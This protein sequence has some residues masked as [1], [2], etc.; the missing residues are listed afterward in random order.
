MSPQDPAPNPDRDP[1]TAP[2]EEEEAAPARR[3]MEGTDLLVKI[4]F[5]VIFVLL[6]TSAWAFIC[7]G[8]QKGWMV[9]LKFIAWAIIFGAF[10]AN[11]WK[12][13]VRPIG[14][15]VAL[16]LLLSFAWLAWAGSYHRTRDLLCMGFS[17]GAVM[18]L[19]PRGR[20]WLKSLYAVIKECAGESV[21]TGRPVIPN[22]TKHRPLKGAWGF[23]FFV[24]FVFLFWLTSSG[25]NAWNVGAPVPTDPARFAALY[26]KSPWRDVRVGVA[27]SGGGYRAVLMHAGVLDAF[28][29]LGVPVT[30]MTSVSGGSITGAFYAAGGE[31]RRLRAAINERRFNLT[32]NMTDAQN[33][34]RLPFPFKLPWTDVK[35][36][37]WYSFTRSDVQSALLDSVLLDQK[38]LSDLKRGAGAPRLM[39]CTTDLYSGS[40]LGFSEEGVLRRFMIQAKEKDDFINVKAPRDEEK[41]V[42]FAVSDEEFP[43]REYLSRLVA[44]SGAFPGAFNAVSEEMY[45]D[46]PDGDAQKK[47]PVLLADGGITDNSALTMLLFA[48]TKLED[49]KVDVAVSSDASALFAEQSDFTALGELSRA[50]DIVYA[51]VGV[52][53]F[54]QASRSPQILLSPASFLDTRLTDEGERR[55]QIKAVFDEGISRL[56]PEALRVLVPD[57]SDEA[58]RR[59]AEE[60]FARCCEDEAAIGRIKEILSADLHES[61]GA[62]LRASTLRDNFDGDDANKIFRLGQYLV[63]LNWSYL[64]AKLEEAKAAKEGGGQPAP[65]AETVLKVGG[66][67]GAAAETTPKRR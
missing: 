20:L 29:T 64:R 5:G 2:A 52:R 6:V 23:I 48:P 16:G 67:A 22:F 57:I 41:S 33:A 26:E 38:K 34:L 37:K 47:K 14:T 44:A 58:Q 10:V 45:L 61:V 9:A 30:H 11:A 54:R 46:K 65:P 40:F 12:Q 51:N 35:L 59:E 53:R 36:F 13:Y 43:R 21:S 7:T 25:L 56:S 66:P 19:L 63:A 42:F 31:P 32:R 55:A 50:I 24:A 15:W 27:L 60:L 4:I 28:E 18:L 49:W 3:E 17:F 39:I 1:T 8:S 62:F